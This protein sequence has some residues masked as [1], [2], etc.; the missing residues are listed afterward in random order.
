MIVGPG[1]SGTGY[2]AKVLN[3]C[4]VACGHEE[5]WNPQ[6]TRRDG[7]VCDA[8]WCA[9]ALGDL[10]PLVLH[11]VRHPL[12]VYTSLLHHPPAGLYR[13]LRL[14]LLDDPPEDP[15]RYA[16]AVTVTYTREALRRSQWGWRV[17]ALDAPLLAQ[18]CA[19]LGFP[20]PHMTAAAALAA[21]PRTVNQH[22]A[23]PWEIDDS[24]DE[25]NAL[26][27]ELGYT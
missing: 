25:L 1:R 4:G 11:Q 15:R 12:A 19:T 20:V 3:M 27:L 8:S 14:R 24:Y 16:L 13:Q 21:V 23:L 9:L 6:R 17:E 7:L 2:I 10:P 26:A 22:T 5:W 18:V